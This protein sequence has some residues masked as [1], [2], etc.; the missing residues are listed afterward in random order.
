MTVPITILGVTV[1][2][3]EEGDLAWG[4][5]ATQF[6]TL[7]GAAVAPIADLYNNNTG[8][9]GYIGLSNGGNLTLS[10]NGGPPIVVGTG[11]ISGSNGQVLVSNGGGNAIPLPYGTAGQVLTS[12]GAGVAPAYVNQSAIIA[13][14]GIQPVGLLPLAGDFE[15]Q[16]IY[17]TTNGLLYRW[18]GSAW[19]A[20]LPT[21][22]LTGLI[23]ELQINDGAIT[24]AKT[25]LAGINAITG[26]IAN[27]AVNVNQLVNGAVTDLKLASGAVTSTKLAV[28][29]I[30]SATGDLNTGVVNNSNVVNGAIDAVKLA[31]AAVTAAKTSLAAI[32][33]SSGNLAINSVTSN[34]ITAGSVIAGKLAVGAVTAGDIAAGAVTAGT[35]AANAITATEL[36]A[37]SVI[38]GKIAA[39]AVTAVTIGAGEVIA[40]KLATDSV[41]SANI[42]AGSIVAGKLAT[43]SVAANN[44]IAGN[45]TA[46]KLATDSVTTNNIVAGNVTGLKIAAG[47]IT[48]T[49]IAAGTITATN[50]AT[51]TI[52]T[53]RIVVGTATVNISLLASGIAFKPSLYGYPPNTTAWNWGGGGGG[54]LGFNGPSITTTASGS[55]VRV[56]CLIQMSV[57]FDNFSAAGDIFR[58][59][60]SITVPGIG[61]SLANPIGQ[62]PIVSSISSNAQWQGVIEWIYV[63]PS[64]GT[65]TVYASGYSDTP[66]L[67]SAINDVTFAGASV[68]WRVQ[69]FKL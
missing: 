53:D 5:S 29:A 45:V 4:Q 66:T 41:V 50:I 16:V 55:Y 7:T 61:S 38:A 48:S 18:N 20:S 25:A 52:T 3:P 30:N 40:G 39:N 42:T 34:N 63:P 14:N 6:A 36:A 19:I 28:A 9:V 51:N 31:N 47:T 15:G 62:M 27:N 2:Y 54:P 10:I 64:I 11:S 32:D 13:G 21:D 56:S 33:S 17:L 68:S 22:Q 67:Y 35:V 65:Y 57:D 58:S 46:G 60:F 1:Q 8:D 26:E 23:Q 37:N 44:I 59:T 12:S 43:D 49:N 69:E 24:A